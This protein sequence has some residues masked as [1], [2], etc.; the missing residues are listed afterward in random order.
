MKN[1]PQ[2]KTRKAFTLVEVVVAMALFVMTVGVL[3]QA[4]NNG[5]LALIIMEQQQSRRDDMLFLREKILAISDRD[6]FESGGDIVVPSGATIRWESYVYPTTAADLFFAIII[7]DFPDT[8]EDPQQ[9]IT[10]TLYLYRPAWSDS[11]ER[12]LLI[13]DFEDLLDDYRPERSQ[14]T[15]EN[16]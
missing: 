8:E 16:G 15:E 14:E 7:F 9:T 6:E 11:A 4:A 10:Q 3:A 2:T 13:D 5:L 12:N 1:I